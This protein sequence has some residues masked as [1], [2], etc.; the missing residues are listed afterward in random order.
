MKILFYAFKLLT[1]LCLLTSCEEKPKDLSASNCINSKKNESD[2]LYPLMR[3]MAELPGKSDHETKFD[4][5]FNDHY[6]KKAGEHHILYCYEEKDTNYLLVYRIAPSISEKY[7]GIGVKLVTSGN[8]SIQYYEESF[9]TWKMPMD[10]LTL[11]GKMLLEELIN[12]ENMA[13]YYPQNSGEEEWIEFP[14]ELTRF[15]A[16]NRKWISDREDVM[17]PYYQL[18]N[19]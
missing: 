6:L 3:Y 7:V 11:K 9:R 1:L 14:D 5:I 2:I 8:D 10:L 15:D 13:Q 4:T 16:T 19:K 12:G 17:E 18:K